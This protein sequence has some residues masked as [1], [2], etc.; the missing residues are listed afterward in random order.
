M[1]WNGATKRTNKLIE[2][3]VSHEDEYLTMHPMGDPALGYSA[4]HRLLAK[5]FFYFFLSRNE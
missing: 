1:N 3:K 4:D 5:L 2:S